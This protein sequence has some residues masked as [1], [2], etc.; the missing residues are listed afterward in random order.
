MGKHKIDIAALL[1]SHRRG[2]R[3]ILVVAHRGSSGK[4]PE[5]TL[6]AFKL[7]VEEGADMIECD[8][9]LTRDGEVVVYHDK[10][11]DR[12][13]DGTGRVEKRTLVE[14]RKVDAG[15]WFNDTFSGERIPTLDEVLELLDE[16]AY[17]NIELKSDS[18]QRRLGSCL[19]ARV[20]ELVK[21]HRAEDWVFLGSFD[22]R[23]MADIKERHP[24]M[25][26]A[27]IYKAVRDFA[28]RPS[29]LVSRAH[30]DAFV[31]GRWWLSRRLLEDLHG[32]KIPL[33]VYTINTQRDVERMVRAKVDGLITNFPELAVKEL[34]RLSPHTR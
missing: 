17:L 31:C 4:A 12:T 1:E 22:H 8:V 15:S 2:E 27:I 21:K 34:H 29:R 28:S 13:T 14:L 18:P 11:L 6:A 24:R 19:E 30:A 7:A 20:V 5:N 3:R 10:T 16:R 33:F 25:K 26:T 32:H 23:L 9:R